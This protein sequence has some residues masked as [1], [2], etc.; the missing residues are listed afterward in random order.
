M[1]QENQKLEFLS[2]ES[3]KFVP[4]DK[5]PILTIVANNLKLRKSDL[6]GLKICYNFNSFKHPDIDYLFG[7]YNEDPSYMCSRDKYKPESVLIISVDNSFEIPKDSKFNYIFID[8]HLYEQKV[9]MCQYQSNSILIY[10]N[11][12]LISKVL[13]KIIKEKEITH[14]GIVFHTDMDGIGSGLLIHR[15]VDHILN[16][17]VE[18]ISQEDLDNIGL[19]A[20]LG[21]YGDIST[22]KEEIL[23]E[24]FRQKDIYSSGLKSKME[25]IN[26]NFGRYLKAIRPIMDHYIHVKDPEP[27]TGFNNSPTI[28]F[29]RLKDKYDE[30]KRK[31]D[32]NHKD[33]YASYIKIRNFFDNTKNLDTMKIVTFLTSIVQDP[34]NRIIID[35]VQKEI[36][37]FVNSYIYP[38]TPVFDMKIQFTNV[39][40]SKDYKLFLFDSPL[41][42]GRSIMW[43]YKGK[44]AYF[45]GEPTRDFSLYHYRSAL[46]YISKA[47]D[48][49]CCYNTFSGKLSLQSSDP[50]NA[51]D[52][53]LAFNGGGH[54]NTDS[55]SIGSAF[56]DLDTLTNSTVLLEVI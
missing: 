3:T 20:V 19:A 6:S 38:T 53:G 32:I 25:K 27:E 55:G 5:N 17:T 28:K 26:K 35:L 30:Y 48:N 22:D 46:P 15:I 39:Q 52:I 14:L 33:F 56:V 40:N 24:V 49:M 43:S 45:K 31:Y 37:F 4:S 16:N 41:D 42:I 11:F 2:D 51:Y 18:T 7:Q 44:V 29:F 13:D 21:E 47:C 9:G 8:H 54:A 50:R 1:M 34:V 36:D 10:K 23:F 12:S